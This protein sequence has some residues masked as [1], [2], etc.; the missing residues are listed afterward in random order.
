MDA[1]T[2]LSLALYYCSCDNLWMQAWQVCRQTSF[3][4][5][6]IR[7]MSIAGK[8]W[9]VFEDVSCYFRPEDRRMCWKVYLIFPAILID[10]IID[11]TSFFQFL[12]FLISLRLTCICPHPPTCAGRGRIKR[13]TTTGMGIT[14]SH[15]A[16]CCVFTWLPSAGQ[17]K[18]ISNI[19]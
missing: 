1:H 10:L 6:L 8:S 4:L 11:I 13:R 15:C 12:P 2:S 9:Q 14:K 16:D 18:N 19:P 5:F 3:V 17:K 7:S